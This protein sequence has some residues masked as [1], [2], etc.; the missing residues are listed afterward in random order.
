MSASRLLPVLLLLC[1]ADEVFAQK[2]CEPAGGLQFICGPKNAED[3]VLVPGT[4]WILSSGKADGAS[5]FA[6]DSR[7]GAW[8]P[9]KFEVK[10]DAAFT[11]C[12]APPDIAHF[13]SH[14]LSIRD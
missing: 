13:E 1:L 5:L 14:G 11:Q 7:N 10:P 2:A 9:L 12:T 3:L 6:I 8:R 4:P